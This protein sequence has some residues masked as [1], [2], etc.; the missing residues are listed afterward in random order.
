MSQGTEGPQ[1]AQGNYLFWALLGAGLV[2][3]IGS[4]ALL[5]K[6]E[7]RPEL[8]AADPAL[9]TGLQVLRILAGLGLGLL[10]LLMLLSLKKTP[11]D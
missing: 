8:A 4:S 1:E 6:M 11:Q 2:V 9:M 10:A 5:N 3:L 7:Q